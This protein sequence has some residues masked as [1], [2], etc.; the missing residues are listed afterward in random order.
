[1]T[2]DLTEQEEIY[3]QFRAAG[4]SKSHAAK[5][6]YN[7]SHPRQMGYEAEQRQHVKNRIMELKEERAESAGLDVNEQIRR[8]NEMYFMAL[9]RGQ[10]TTAKQ[11]LQR[12]DAIGGFEAPSKSISMSYKGDAN[13]VLK[14]DDLK[15]DIEKFANVLGKHTD[16]PNKSV[17]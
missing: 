17:H 11:M 15:K 14:G 1:M 3:A 10:L 16:Q 8:Y 5:K 7:T 4:Y 13:S 2:Y 6:A 12:I 9:E